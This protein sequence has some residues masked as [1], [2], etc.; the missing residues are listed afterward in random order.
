MEEEGKNMPVNS[1]ATGRGWLA[2]GRPESEQGG[3]GRWKLE[4]IFGDCGV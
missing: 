3:N 1:T 2:T 4:R